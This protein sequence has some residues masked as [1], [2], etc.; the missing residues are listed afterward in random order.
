MVRLWS[1]GE[2]ARAPDA[3]FLK[4]RLLA[5]LDARRTL[6][7]ADGKSGYR[8]FNAEGDGL[9]GLTADVYG[10]FAVV[11]ALS[12]GLL[13]HARLLAQCALELLPEPVCRCGAPC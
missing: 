6:G 11:T 13:G 9:S 4:E 7:L 3:A 2:E 12:R 5:A 1:H 10:P 8:L